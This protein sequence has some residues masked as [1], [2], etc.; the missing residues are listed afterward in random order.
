M[1][2]EKPYSYSAH[3]LPHDVKVRELGSGVSRLVTLHKMGLTN[4]RIAPKLGLQDGIN[5]LRNILPRSWF[6]KTKCFEGFEAL[7]A[8]RRKY[9]R[10]LGVFSKQPIHDGNSHFADGARTY[11]QGKFEDVDINLLPKVAVDIDQSPI[12]HRRDE[13]YSNPDNYDPFSRRFYG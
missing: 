13:R 12:W 2:R 11:A 9:D 8:Y 1:I 7:K 5:A 6:D 10:A 3:I 4:T